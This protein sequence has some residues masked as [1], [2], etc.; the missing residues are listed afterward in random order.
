MSRAAIAWN[1][2]KALPLAETAGWVVIPAIF[3][4]GLFCFIVYCAFAGMPRSPRLDRISKNQ[5]LP[6][7]V[8]EFGYVCVM[9]LPVRALVALGVSADAVSYLSLAVAL[10]GA[11]FFGRGWLTVG[12]WLFYLSFILDGM[13]GMV[14]RASGKASN[15]GEFLDALLDRYVD[16]AVSLGMMWYYRDEPLPL[17]LAVACM[18]GASVMGYARAKG[19][20]CGVDPNVGF[21]M[22]HERG[23]LLG[24]ACILSPL[25][26]AMTEPGATHPHHWLV[27]GAMAIVAVL[28]N[29][30]ALWRAHFVL[31][32]MTS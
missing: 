30:S 31:T 9:G 4:V 17:A 25:F 26:A 15:R 22:R 3:V 24:T 1:A 11:C 29:I 28:S 20:A 19:E 10:A 2:V 8:L 27:I 7:I 6:R 16:F 14:A 32:R 13:D 5:L 23:V 18:V 21:M 12:G